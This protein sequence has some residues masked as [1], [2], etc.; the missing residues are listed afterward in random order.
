MATHTAPAP[1]LDA[2]SAPSTTDDAES[3][4]SFNSKVQQNTM[5]PG[6]QVKPPADPE[7]ATVLSEDGAADAEVKP[8]PPG[9]PP[10]MAPSDFPDGGTQ[11]WLT[12]FGG[13]CW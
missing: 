2:K 5:M 4:T 8:P 6:Q 7:K 13:W 9:P 3:A 11:A 12:C 10:G 1:G